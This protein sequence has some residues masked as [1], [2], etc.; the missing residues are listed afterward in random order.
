MSL[1]HNEW[2]D[3]KVN[4]IDVLDDPAFQGFSYDTDG[5]LGTPM[6]FVSGG[7]SCY[8][9]AVCLPRCSGS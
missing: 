4:L 8:G 6:A 7:D 2:Q 5:V 9:T 1:E 3:R